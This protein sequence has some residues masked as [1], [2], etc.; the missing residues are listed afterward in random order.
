MNRNL[1]QIAG[2]TALIGLGSEAMSFIFRICTRWVL[3]ASNIVAPGFWCLFD[4]I[5]FK[6]CGTYSL[7]MVLRRN[8]SWGRCKRSAFKSFPVL[9]QV[10][11]FEMKRNSSWLETVW[12]LL[13]QLVICVGGEDCWIGSSMVSLNSGDISSHSTVWTTSLTFETIA[14]V[15]QFRTQHS[16]I[17][18]CDK[19]PQI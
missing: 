5:S 7:H 10:Q 9:Q 3:A 13:R 17:F 1:G 2:R 12:I 14:R 8:F 16:I 11:K 15:S 4:S 6:I 19:V 18:F